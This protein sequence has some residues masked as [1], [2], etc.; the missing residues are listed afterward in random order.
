MDF[1]LIQRDRVILTFSA[2]TRLE[3]DQVLRDRCGRDLI[4]YRLARVLRTGT[5]IATVA[6]Q[7]AE[8]DAL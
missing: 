5:P 2:A 7:L 8:T 6:R 1:L 4:E 3:A